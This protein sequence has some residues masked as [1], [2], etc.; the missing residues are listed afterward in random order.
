V[1][2]NVRFDENIRRHLPVL[3]ID[4]WGCRID[5]GGRKRRPGRMRR[6]RRPAGI[7]ARP[8]DESLPVGFVGGA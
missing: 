4:L 3:W 8:P 2:K 6:L 5:F 1:I 7:L